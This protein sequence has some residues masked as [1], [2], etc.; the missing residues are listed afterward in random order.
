MLAFQN[1]YTLERR[2]TSTTDHIF[3]VISVISC[4]F[5]FSKSY[6]NYLEVC[7][8]YF[9]YSFIHKLAELLFTVR[10]IVS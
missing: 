9:G 6:T 2:M 1:I 10:I 7:I 8:L 4:A 3:P 5:R